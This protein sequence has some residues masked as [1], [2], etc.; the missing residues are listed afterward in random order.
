DIW[1]QPLQQYGDL[2]GSYSERNL[3][4]PSDGLH[5]FAGVLSA[6]SEHLGKSKM[7]YGVPAAAFDWGLLWQGID[8]LTRRSCFPSWTWVGF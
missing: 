6:L 5:A 8:E 1:D 4:F 7:F 2:V 3:T